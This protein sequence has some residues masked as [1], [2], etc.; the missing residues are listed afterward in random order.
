MSVAKLSINGVLRGTAWLV[1]PT[2][3]ITAA[4]CVPRTLG[5]SVELR[6]HNPNGGL[7]DSI[8]ASV[9]VREDALDGALL[10]LCEALPVN[11]SA[12][13][14]CRRG[15]I[16]GMAWNGIGFPQATETH[17]HGLKL[18]GEIAWNQSSLNNVDSPPMIQLTCVQAANFGAPIHLDGMGKPVHFLAGAS[19]A[20][21]QVAT[22]SNR[23]VGFVRCSPSPIANTTIYATPLDY[24][25]Q[26]FEEHLTG[27]QIHDWIG[28]PILFISGGDSESEV[29]T[30]YTAS[31][32]DRLWNGTSIQKIDT[33]LSHRSSIAIATAS[34]RLMIHSPK[35]TQLAVL[36]RGG[37]AVE[38]KAALAEWI[39][40]RVNPLDITSR[41]V[42]RNEGN[43][44][45]GTKYTVS[46]LAL[47]IHRDCDLWCLT[48]LDIRLVEIFDSDKPEMISSY[49]IAPDV[50]K[51]MKVVW[52]SWYPQLKN[53]PVLLHH[54]FALMLTPDGR[55]SCDG[56][57]CMG[58][59]PLTVDECMLPTLLFC[60]A[61]SPCL[62]GK[63]SPR[64]VPPGN[65]GHDTFPAHACGIRIHRYQELD[66]ALR[67]HL[68]FT[69]VVLL[70]GLIQ[71]PA[72]WEVEMTSF[73]TSLSNERPSLNRSPP[74]SVLLCCDEKIRFA[75]GTSLAAI[76][77][78]VD[79]RY[80]ELQKTQKQYAD[81]A[82]NIL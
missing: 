78:Y 11:M 30:N 79:F 22:Q 2:H 67:N 53:D 81:N 71:S 8:A 1:T 13:S 58:I 38:M 56:A 35:V 77:K 49:S 19:G 34:M 42:E 51:S 7:F 66:I 62:S 63:F 52:E 24:L 55:H 61:L 27:I 4:H 31:D 6:F 40:V 17:V 41:C 25:W 3:A 33:N 73:G 54:F 28:D 74:T 5:D 21:V 60:L 70:P 82:A 72:S 45:Q 48:R 50:L 20:P 76:Q 44:A 39:P 10:R 47:A 43:I 46:E 57:A 14:V 23:V 69:R 16:E 12:L 68:W 64:G 65:V 37:W 9:V 59:G 36:G 18:T 26:H 32:V 29:Q 80:E 15:T 75:I